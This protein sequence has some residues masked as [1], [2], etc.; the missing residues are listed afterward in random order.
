MEEKALAFC[1]RV[2]GRLL[3]LAQE[4]QDPKTQELL[5]LLAD[6]CIE[7]LLRAETSVKSRREMLH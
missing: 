1:K 2:A 3:L 6:D 7:F 4:C 5:Q